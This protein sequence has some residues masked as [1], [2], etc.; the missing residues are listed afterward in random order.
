[1]LRAAGIVCALWYARQQKCA[2]RFVSAALASAF[3]RLI[4]ALVLFDRNNAGVREVGLRKRCATLYLRSP[5]SYHMAFN[6]PNAKAKPRPSIQLKY[7]ITD[8]FV[9]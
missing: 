6:T 7:H 9:F 3:A 4:V 2:C 5:N 8:S 1:M